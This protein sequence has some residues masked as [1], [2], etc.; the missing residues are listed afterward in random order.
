MFQ[1]DSINL[2]NWLCFQFLI[3]F[4]NKISIR[5]KVTKYLNQIEKVI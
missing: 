4:E 5:Q 3:N 2:F 1:I